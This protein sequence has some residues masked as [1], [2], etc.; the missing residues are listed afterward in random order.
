[1][2]YTQGFE[3]YAQTLLSK[4]ILNYLAHIFL[5]GNDPR[6]QVGNFIGDFVKGNKFND[7]PLRI[8]EGILLHRKID[9]FT[10]SHPIVKETVVLLRPVFGRYS[11]II[12]DMY[13]D[14]FL[15]INFTI[16]H[17]SKSLKF[18]AFR[19]YISVLINYK[20]LPDRV[21]G[22]IF[23]FVLTNRLFKYS[24]LNGLKGSLEIMANYKISA[25]NPDETINF[26]IEN[27]TDLERRFHLFFPDLV[28]F[29]SEEI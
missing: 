16:Y 5:S 1:L 2:Q 15:A 22:F 10:D 23:H 6:L 20:H 14:Y 29:V 4:Y 12:A 9:S 17:S 8:R 13:F 21:K 26:L 19:F 3:L 25:I 11:A 24:K 18:F 28:K 7:Y 27:H